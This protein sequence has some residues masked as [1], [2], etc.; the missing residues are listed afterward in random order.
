MMTGKYT[1]RGRLRETM[2]A[3][4]K[5]ANPGISDEE[6]YNLWREE[7]KKRGSEGGKKSTGAFAVVPGLAQRAGKLSRA[8]K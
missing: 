7:M 4:Y 2:I 8:K 5:Q 1:N 3:K 6:A